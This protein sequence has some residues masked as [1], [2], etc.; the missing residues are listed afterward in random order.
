MCVYVCM[1][2]GKGGGEGGVVDRVC[3]FIYV[4]IFFIFLVFFY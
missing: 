3:L 1:E 4:F 2:A